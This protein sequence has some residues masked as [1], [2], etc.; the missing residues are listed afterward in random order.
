MEIK[1]GVILAGGTGSRLYPLTK[2][3]NKHFLNVYDKPMIYYSLSILL[4]LKV[5]EISI[6]ID[7]ESLK[8]A[9]NLLG[10][11]V[12]F[13]ININYIVQD[14]PLGLPDAISKIF[15]SNDE[16]EK[17]FVVLGDNFLYGREFYN[18]FYDLVDLNKSNIF[19]Q[20][21]HNPEDFAVLKVN[22]SN[23]IESII[24]KPKTHISDLAVTGI[25][26]FDKR[27]IEYFRNT[28]MSSRNEFEITDILNCYHEDRSLNATYLGR[29]MTWMDMG[30]NESLISCANFVRT[31][32]ERQN[33]LVNSPHEIA[34]RNEWVTEED[35][36][37]IYLKHKNSSYFSNLIDNIKS[38]Y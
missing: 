17:F 34:Y 28:D 8:I 24:E 20:K 22:E 9:Q 18:N 6:V 37:K 26:T 30:N 16:I 23:N 33:I 1:N 21:V 29:G 7:Q 38:R 15:D 36:Y 5:K 14:S 31:I 27:F 10:D 2:T 35:L 13:G 19:Y 11:G 12:E 25:Y 32:Q 3:T 4:L